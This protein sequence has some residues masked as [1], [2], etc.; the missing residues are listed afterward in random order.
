M[1]ICI[2]GSF[3][4]SIKHPIQI[5]PPW[6]GNLYNEKNGYPFAGLTFEFS[7]C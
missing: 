4:Y 5:A 6:R 7:I 1:D 3:G 2:I